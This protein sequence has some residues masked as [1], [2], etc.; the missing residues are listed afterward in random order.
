MSADEEKFIK[1]YST[2][3]CGHKFYAFMTTILMNMTTE[4]GVVKRKRDE[5]RY[6]IYGRINCHSFAMISEY[7]TCCRDTDINYLSYGCIKS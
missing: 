7:N 6:K 3:A 5:R 4:S 1:N 2:L